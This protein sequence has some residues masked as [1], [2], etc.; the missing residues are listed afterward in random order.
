MINTLAN[1]KNQI[2]ITFILIG[3]SNLSYAHGFYGGSGWLHP[4]TGID[5]VMAMIAVGAW[6]AQIGGRAIWYVPSTFLLAMLVGGVSGYLH[7]HIPY[8]EFGVSISV[9]LLGLAI[10]LECKITIL[11]AAVVV[12]LFGVCHGYAH[13]AE[14]PLQ[15]NKAIYT[16]GFLATTAGLHIFGAT[17]AMLILDNSIRSRGRLYLRVCGAICAIIGIYLLLKLLHINIKF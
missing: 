15:Q 8:T 7:L 3:L 13:G 16:I 5:H 1:R 4:L 12:A 6:S 17:G 9:F 14:M 11:L 10:A 2:L